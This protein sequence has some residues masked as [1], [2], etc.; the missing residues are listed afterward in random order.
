MKASLEINS[1]FRPY[2]YISYKN[3]CGIFVS[4]LGGPWE[5]DC[6]PDWLLYAILCNSYTFPW[7]NSYSND[8]L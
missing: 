1:I 7:Y 2:M 4:E 5:K 6:R 8:L 3:K